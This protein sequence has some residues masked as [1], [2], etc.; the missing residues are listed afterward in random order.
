MIESD[1]IQGRKT[2]LNGG[3]DIQE[4]LMILF[5]K[6]QLIWEPPAFKEDVMG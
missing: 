6:E 3:V 1:S 5:D 2:L 4:T